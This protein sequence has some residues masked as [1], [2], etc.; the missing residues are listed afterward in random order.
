M[1]WRTKAKIEIPRRIPEA[2]GNKITYR[3]YC[4]M[5]SA[6]LLLVVVMAMEVE[7]HWIRPI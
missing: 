1:G 2:E 6:V 4:L 5:P 3:R 7:V